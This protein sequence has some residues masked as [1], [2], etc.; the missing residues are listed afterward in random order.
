MNFFSNY[1]IFDA[2]YYNPLE[3]VEK[4]DVGF[5]IVLEDGRKLRFPSPLNLRV[6]ISNQTDEDDLL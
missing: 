1:S 4:D 2:D 5:F 6:E 3:N